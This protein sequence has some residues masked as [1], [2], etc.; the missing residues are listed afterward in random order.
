MISGKQ[1]GR[2]TLLFYGV[3][4]L[5]LFGG[6]CM[7]GFNGL[8]GQD[9][10]EYARYANEWREFFLQGKAPG[11]YFWPLLYPILGG[12]L[13]L[14]IPV[15][16]ALQIVSVASLT[17]SCW[18]LEKTL[19]RQFAV[20]IQTSRMYAVLFLL[21]SPFVL[22][23]GLTDM[24]DLLATFF[25]ILSWY[26]F[27]VLGQIYTRKHTFLFTLAASAAVMTRYAC[28]LLVLVPA[29]IV[30]YRSLKHLRL[31]DYLVLL[32]ILSLISLPHFAIRHSKPFAFLA[33]DWMQ[34]WS[35]MNFFLTS[36][37]NGNG[38][39]SYQ[40][41]NIVYAFLS[42]FHPGFLFCGFILVFFR[43]KIQLK[44]PLTKTL[45]LSIS[46]YCLFLAGIP[47][48]N[49]RFLIPAFPLFLL[50]FFPVYPELISKLNV[51]PRLF[52]AGVIV[53]QI[54]LFTRAFIPFYKANSE[55]RS[56]A[57]A[58]T[59]LPPGSIYTFSINGALNFYGI[60][61]QKDNLWDKKLD[62]LQK[63]SFLLFNLHSFEKEYTGL[64][65]MINYEF[66][67]SHSDLHEMKQLP[68]GW[69][70]YEIR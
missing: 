52:V 12:F 58:C 1:T 24:S 15:Q 28:A 29:I 36:F 56:I 57:Q 23:A 60:V 47:F 11:D 7:A 66:I 2:N 27:I 64:N 46:L 3:L 19:R 44:D 33:T 62:T 21:L 20:S 37:K 32:L 9:S 25:V 31:T 10:Y 30:V 22:R 67:R 4:F 34:E 50:F 42:F 45:L 18:L 8:Y 63:N 17:A 6:I 49:M 13:S 5:A 48:Q 54:G 70:L 65:P 69:T 41:Q 39:Y 55:E 16:Y 43:N 53:I 26:C 40:V 61:L 51:T 59:K 14:L 38:H 35:P 68:G